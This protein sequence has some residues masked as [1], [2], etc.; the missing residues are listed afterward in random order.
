MAMGIH[1]AMG[2]VMSLMSLS[3]SLTHHWSSVARAEPRFCSLGNNYVNL[4]KY[5]RSWSHSHAQGVLCH[6]Y[7][8]P[9]K[10]FLRYLRA[11]E[12]KMAQATAI[13]KQ[14][15]WIDKF[16][17]TGIALGSS[18]TGHRGW[19][20]LKGWLVTAAIAVPAHFW[21]RHGWHVANIKITS[22]H[23]HTYMIIATD[24]LHYTKKPWAW[25]WVWLHIHLRPGTTDIMKPSKL[26]SLVA[27]GL[28]A[29]PGTARSRLTILE[30]P[31]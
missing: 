24:K 16:Y 4:S 6:L 15:E 11:F 5:W 28:Q 17:A 7:G 8:A 10:P 19:T 30:S 21:V 29:R 31:N 20:W 3:L 14:L 27:H 12:K 26:A 9:R 23:Q 25:W 13:S 22:H 18:L 1:I 2:C